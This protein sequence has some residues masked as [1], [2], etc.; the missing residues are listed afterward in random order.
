MNSFDEAE[1]QALIAHLELADPKETPN[2]NHYTFYPKNLA[3]AT[4]YF[5]TFRTDLTAACASLAARGL[6]TAVRTGYELTPTGKT[7]AQLLRDA[8]PPI[9]YFYKE[10][11]SE[12]PHSPAFA[13]FCEALY[14]KHLHQSNFS[15]MAQ[16]DKLLEVAQ[17]GPGSRVLDL[18]CG[19]GMI[20]E[21][22]SDVTGAHV[23]GIDY[24]PEAI[25]EAQARTAAKRDRLHFATG[26]LDDLVAAPPPFDALVSIDTLYMPKDLDATLAQMYSLLAPDGQMLIYWM[27]MVWDPAASRSV[28]EADHTTLAK[29]LQRAGLP[30]RTWDFSAATYALMQRK[31]QL[32]QA[33]AADFAAEGRPF[34][35]E[36]LVAESE[37][38]P[39]PF[40]PARA[41]L[42]RYLYQVTL[43]L[44]TSAAQRPPSGR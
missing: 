9:W 13:R 16:L 39:A 25:A 19:V 4:S 43:S 8:R 38:N 5:R 10:Y 7:A 37:S 33:M 3:E 42:S 20:A 27:E 15:D 26:N 14:G 17:L 18:G 28:L 34:L 2:N 30:Y 32:A 24:M 23:T 36:H 41:N 29:A 12:A 35:F 31:H 1:I 22:I 11:Y 21:Y 40:D 44:P 6:M